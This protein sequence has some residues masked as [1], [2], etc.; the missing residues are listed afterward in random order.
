MELLNGVDQF[1]AP[2]SKTS[3]VGAYGLVGAKRCRP[4]GIEIGD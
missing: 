2:P 1:V 4:F 3:A